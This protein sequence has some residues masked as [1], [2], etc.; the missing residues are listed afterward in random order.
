M[1]VMSTMSEL[2]EVLISESEFCALVGCTPV[3]IHRDK[4]KKFVS[5]QDIY[6]I[7][8]KRETLQMVRNLK[9]K[10]YI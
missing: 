10:H 8:M 9:F 6:W 3:E 5:S 2:Y 7:K 1:L 4:W